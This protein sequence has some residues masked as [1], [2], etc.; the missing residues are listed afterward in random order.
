[1]QPIT[2]QEIRLIF[3]GIASSL[4]IMRRANIATIVLHVGYCIYKLS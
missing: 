2:T 4:S 1:M 3:D